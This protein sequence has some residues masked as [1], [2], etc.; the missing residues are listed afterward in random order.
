MKATIPGKHSRNVS[1]IF[2]LFIPYQKA[3]PLKEIKT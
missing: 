2:N 1:S 3:I